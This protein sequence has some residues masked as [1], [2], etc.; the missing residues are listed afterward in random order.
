MAE[1]DAMME[2]QVLDEAAVSA[3]APVVAEEAT[4]K[5]WTRPSIKDVD[6]NA[7]T[8]STLSPLRCLFLLLLLLFC[9]VLF[10]FGPVFQQM[11]TDFYLGKAPVEMHKAYTPGGADPSSSAPIIRF[12]G[13]TKEGNSVM[14]HVHGFRPY[15]YVPAPANFQTSNLEYI[16]QALCEQLA[17]NRA[18][19]V[20]FQLE[21]CQKE[22]IY[23]FHGNKKIPFIRVYT[24]L[25][26]QIAKV[27]GTRIFV[28]QSPF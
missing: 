6:H 11:D 25:P 15:F 10:C 4:R 24:A 3:L 19:D 2:Q 14:C 12:F 16:R 20:R 17:L 1:M 9:F 7:D 5:Y 27:K 8:I 28:I 21:V 26:S 18:S 13:V 22:S 23:G